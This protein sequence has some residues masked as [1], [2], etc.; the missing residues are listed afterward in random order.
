MMLTVLKIPFS[1]DG[2]LG[3][4]IS[5]HKQPGSKQQSIR[6]PPTRGPALPFAK[7]AISKSGS[8]NLRVHAYLYLFYPRFHRRQSLP[9]TPDS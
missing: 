5:K 4:R 6:A 9:K 8:L 2:A 1:S 3:G 7:G